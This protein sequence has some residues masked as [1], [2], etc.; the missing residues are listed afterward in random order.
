M[1][2]KLAQSYLLYD[3]YVDQM[4]AH[5]REMDHNIACDNCKKPGC[6]KQVIVATE[7][8]IAAIAQVVD[9]FKPYL[10]KKVDHWCRRQLKVPLELAV[11]HL[12]AF[13]RNAWCPFLTNGK[14]DIY[15]VRPFACRGYFALE[16]DETLCNDMK[17]IQT[18]RQLDTYPIYA[19]VM[20]KSIIQEDGTIELPLTFVLGLG[21]CS[22]L[23]KGSLG[24]KASD[25]AVEIQQYFLENIEEMHKKIQED[26]KRLIL[27]PDG[28]VHADS[29]E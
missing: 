14:C 17:T 12:H 7:D 1:G 22:Y 18:V 23:N 13:E 29:G 8:E 3:R 9:E 26:S 5:V 2:M 25:R 15:P 10:K 16:E 28:G 6:C 4:V 20:L 21:V 19:E 11:D 27:E 24:N